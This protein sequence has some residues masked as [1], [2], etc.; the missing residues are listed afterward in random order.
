MRLIALALLL[1]SACAACAPPSRDV[2]DFCGV[3]AGACGK[4]LV[5]ADG[6][7]H[8]VVCADAGR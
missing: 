1:L 6:G 8:T 4:T 3:P 7:S 2:S 5:D